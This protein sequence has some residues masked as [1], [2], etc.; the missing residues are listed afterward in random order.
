MRR[1]HK[2]PHGSWILPACVVLLAMSVVSWP[3]PT[4]A[5]ILTPDQA[6]ELLRRQRQDSG[7]PVPLVSPLDEGRRGFQEGEELRLLLEQLRRQQTQPVGPP[8]LL[9]RDYSD[10]LGQDVRQF[11]YDVFRRGPVLEGLL[12]GRIQESYKLG[13][14]D[15]LIVTFRGQISRSVAV[16]VDREGRVILPDLPPISAAG[17]TFSEFVHELEARIAATLLGTE[18][19]VSVGALRAVSVI[20]IGE[21]ANPGLLQL[22]GMS[23]LIDVLI[24]VGGIKKTGSLRRIRVVRGDS[25]SWFDAYDLL[26]TGDFGG[27]LSVV[28][29]DRILVPTIGSTVAIAGEVKRPGI[30]ELAEGQKSIALADVLRLA[31][32]TLRPAGNRYL[33]ITPDETGRERVLEHADVSAVSLREG[34]IVIVGFKENVQ[35]GSVFLDGHVRVPGRRSLA[36]AP[37]VRSLIGDVNSLK[38]DPYLLFA[39]L[40]TTDQLTQS[41]LFVPIDLQR[42]LSGQEDTALRAEDRLIV[43][44]RSDIRY[45]ASSDVQEILSGRNLRRD[46]PLPIEEETEDELAGSEAVVGEEERRVRLAV[47]RAPCVGLVSLFSV[48][49]SSMPGRFGT[50]LRIAPRDLNVV[51]STRVP[52]PAMYERYPDLLPFVLEHVVAVNGEVR[53]PGAYPILPTTSLEA[54]VAYA[55]RSTRQADLTQVELSRPREDPSSGRMLIERTLVNVVAA[56]APSVTV[57]PGDVIRFNSL[58][59]DRD[60][61]PVL[62]LG[63]FV[64]PGLYE[65]RRGER[66]TDVIERAGGLTPQAYPIGAV[67]TRERVKGIEKAGF[68]RAA[69]ELQEALVVALSRRGEAGAQAAASAGAIRDLAQTL[70]EAKAVGRVVIEADPALLRTRPELDTILEGGDRLFMPKLPNSVTVIGDVLNPGTLQFIRGTRVESYIGQAGGLRQSADESRIFVVLPNGA[71]QKISV[72]VWNRTSVDILPG[73]T[74]VVP[75]EPAPFEL[76]AFLKD[77]TAIVSQL[78]ITGAALAVIGNK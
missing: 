36:A 32:G 77:A 1:A 31:G 29:G 37:T 26:F 33:H 14:G 57:S 50:A 42:L 70:R 78:A 68:E 22:T 53:T 74:I 45:I 30:Y 13:I 4:A 38:D 65:I 56:G 49:A 51:E 12:T 39:V 24:A 35:I 3:T 64:R 25:M 46:A 54:V 11:G 63:E 52:C 8:S 61:L 41:R 48:I 72:S 60:E 34:D 5:Q 43:L 44:S 7:P 73:S 18:V 59:S 19:F 55:G 75:K 27:D 16:R 23:S 40:Q 71:A 9:E 15:E 6:E 28:Q 47:A 10:R 67:F 58:F 62:L 76:F 69:R 17:R 20:V 2:R 21:V 66:L